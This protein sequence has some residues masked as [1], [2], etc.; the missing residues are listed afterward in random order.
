MAVDH[1]GLDGLL[2]LL[3]T[4]ARRSEE[5]AGW[6]RLLIEFRVL[7]ARDPELG[8]RYGGLHA[9]A[10]DQFAEAARSVLARGGLAPVYPPRVFAELIFSMD[11][12]LVLERAADPAALPVRYLEDLASR[13]VE[14]I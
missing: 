6:L 5:G 8:R 13:L 10:L 1:A 9:R 3:R 11:A 12:G 7:A 4:N 14:P 2:A